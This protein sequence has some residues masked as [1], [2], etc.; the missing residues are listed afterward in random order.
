M[1]ERFWLSEYPP[2]VVTDIDPDAVISLKEVL[3]STCLRYKPLTAYSY[4]GTS[5]TYGELD[6]LSR[7][8]GAYLQNIA[9]LQ[10]GD[11]VALMLPNLLPYPVALFGALRAG[12]AVVPINPQSIP[13][14]LKYQLNDS[15]AAAIVVLEDY[16]PVLD[17]I[18]QQTALKTVIVVQASDLLS[19]SKTLFSNLASYFKKPKVDLPNAIPFKQVLADSEAED[20]G[21][22]ELQADDLALVQYTSGVTGV[23]RG[24]ALNHRHLVANIQQITAW[25]SP[26]LAVGKEIFINA[27]PLHYLFPLTVNLFV[28]VHL[29][30]HNLLVTDLVDRDNLM[31]ELRRTKFSV[32]TGAN[33]LFS[34]LLDTPGF[35]KLDF[36]NLKLALGTGMK[37]HTHVAQQWR[38]ITG[39]PL[40]EAYGLTEAGLVCINAL[41]QATQ[42]RVGVPLPSTE[43]SIRDEDGET[44]PL[45][46]D[47]GEICV[48][49]HQ[50]MSG[51]WNRPGE[52]AKVLRPGGW[53][54]TGDLGYLDEQ[55]YLYFVERKKDVVQVAGQIVYPTE[56]E[57]VVTQH[58]WVSEAVAV[59]LSGDDGGALLKLIVVKK[60]PNL[61][62]EAVVQ[63]CRLY[64]DT[65]KVPRQVE[66]RKELPKTSLGVVLRRAL[67]QETTSWQMQAG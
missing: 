7:R 32:L 4:S 20:L 56:I 12:Y 52:T 62:A 49:G 6:N 53:L 64:L 47:I 45:I 35:D 55:G 17:E 33:S 13:L 41:D 37:I 43:V 29:A 54:R 50:V 34:T 31:R 58:P 19:G 15:G 67:R 46:G 16:A 9:H 5:L 18:I 10:R 48:R 39:V 42:G 2:G 11:R 30:A 36:S 24:V 28:G 65:Y 44:L 25:I 59:G 1:G 14:D 61:T 23:A 8:F 57:T 66:F 63:H 38:K 3:E 27:L 40:V 51:Y 26:P 22:L 60:D 21:Y